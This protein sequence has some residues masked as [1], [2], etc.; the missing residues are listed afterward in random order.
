MTTELRWE[1][2]ERGAG[3]ASGEPFRP[4]V[5]ELATGMAPADWVAEQPEAHLLPHIRRAAEDRGL[6]VLEAR[7]EGSVYLV[8][9]EWAPSG[10]QTRG[11]LREDVYRVIGSFAELSTH[12]LERL[13]DDAVEFDV[14]TGM[15]AATTPFRPHG[16]LVRLRLEGEAARRLAG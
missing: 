9:L 10:D 6:R 8:R 11:Q 5:T 1:G 14:T 7:S 3:V 12:V 15:L 13:A 16:H 4:G 2:D